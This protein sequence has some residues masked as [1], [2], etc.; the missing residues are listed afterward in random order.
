LGPSLRSVYRAA[1]HLYADSR[2]HGSHFARLLF[3]EFCFYAPCVPVNYC[4]SR[5]TFLHRKMFFSS[6]HLSSP[7][8]RVLSVVRETLRPSSLPSRSLSQGNSPSTSVSP[9]KWPESCPAI[10]SSY[11]LFKIVSCQQVLTEEAYFVPFL[12]LPNSLL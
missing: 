11:L 5:P 3:R 2:V 12:G 1:S 9:S 4:L 8:V 7:A 6:N 10:A